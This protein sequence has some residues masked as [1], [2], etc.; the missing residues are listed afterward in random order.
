MLWFY[1]SIW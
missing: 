1:I